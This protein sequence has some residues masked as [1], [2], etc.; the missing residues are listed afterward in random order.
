MLAGA[1]IVRKP[2][3]VRVLQNG[4]VEC[5][6]GFQVSIYD[7]KLRTVGTGEYVG[8]LVQIWVMLASGQV[9]SLP[10]ISLI[11]D[12]ILLVVTHG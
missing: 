5:G 3:V 1:V 10:F 4:K 8:H 9:Q 6:D 7:F 12:H 11:E 2:Y